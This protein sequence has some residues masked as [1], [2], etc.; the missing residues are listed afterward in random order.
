M[1]Y[2]YKNRRMEEACRKAGEEEQRKRREQKKER[3]AER[4]RGLVRA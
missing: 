2:T 3:P 1:C 4:D